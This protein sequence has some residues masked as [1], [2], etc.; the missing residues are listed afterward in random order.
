M[1]SKNSNGKSNSNNSNGKSNNSNG[2][3]QQ[4]ISLYRFRYD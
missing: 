4:Q 2:K 3:K 1:T